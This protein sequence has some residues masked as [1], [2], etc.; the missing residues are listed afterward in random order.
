MMSGRKNAGKA[1]SFLLVLI[2]VGCFFATYNFLTMVG[3]GRGRD[4]PRK[5]LDHD[6]ALSF[7]SGSD[8]S[9]RFHVAL[10]ATDA[11]YSQWQSRIM[12]YWY[13]EM[14][15]RPGSDMGGFTRILHSGKPDGLMDEI[16]TLVVDP[17]PEGADKVR[18]SKIFHFVTS[19]GG[20]DITFRANSLFC[21]GL[22]RPQQA[23]GVRPVVAKGGHRGGVSRFSVVSL[24]GLLHYLVG[25]LM[26]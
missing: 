10:T 15:G 8:P 16:P 21:S 9:K 7:A 6:G 26:K 25:F 1:S 23:L 24:F 11:L 4:G 3:H 17:L 5:M 22:H 13:K 14:R 2:S 20:V 18:L 12:H 19:R